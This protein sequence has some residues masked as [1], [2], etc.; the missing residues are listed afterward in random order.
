MFAT[1]V[2]SPAHLE[3]AEW[4]ER[5]VHDWLIAIVR[6]AV[7]L[8]EADR[9]AVLARAR[10]MDAPG[11]VQGRITFSYFVRTSTQVCDATADPASSDRD[12]ILGRFVAAIGK[13]RLREVLVAAFALDAAPQ[14]RGCPA[15]AIE[16]PR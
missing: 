1:Y 13:R 8:E 16:L 10:E 4:R 11:C 14:P 15:E 6:F 9:K 2:V 3:D 7:T 12:A 5:K